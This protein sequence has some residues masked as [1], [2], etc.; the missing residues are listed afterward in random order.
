[1]AE[2]LRISKRFR[3]IYQMIKEILPTLS[4]QVYILKSCYKQLALTK[5]LVDYGRFLGCAT[6]Y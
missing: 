2:K 5:P 3:S 1:M 6:F 4:T